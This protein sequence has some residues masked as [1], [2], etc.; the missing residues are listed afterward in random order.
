MVVKEPPGSPTEAETAR[1]LSLLVVFATASPEL[2]RKEEKHVENPRPEK[3]SK[4]TEVSE[5]LAASEVVFVTEYRG[6]SVGQLANLR[7]A[8]RGVDA[9]HKVYKNTLAR[10]A[11]VNSGKSALS[12]LLIGPSS[13]TFVHGDVA[14]TAKVLR[15]FSK[16]NPLLVIKGGTM[17]SDLLSAKYV[18]TLADLP[19]REVMLA[20]FAGLLQA[21]PRNLA[22][23]I[24]A[25]IDQKAA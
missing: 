4:V 6:L 5:K 23:G 21:L 9:E 11:A 12:E 24:K 15:E 14:A 7:S 20:Q 17:G 8:L 22:Y 13:L 10:I 19:S 25:L 1:S 3:V 2:K 18:E 16:T